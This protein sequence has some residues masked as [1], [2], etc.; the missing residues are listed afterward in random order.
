MD[1]L[2]RSQ[3]HR[4]CK[5]TS[6]R[7]T[8]GAAFLLAVYVAALAM[9]LLGGVSLQR[10]TTEV[11]ASQMSRNVHQSFWIAEAGLDHALM[12][13]RQ[14]K[15]LTAQ[16]SEQL[17][18]TLGN[19][20]Y[21]KFAKFSTLADGTY[22]PFTGSG[23][24]YSFTLQTAK[25]EVLSPQAMQLTRTIT[26]TGTAAGRQSSVAATVVSNALPVSGIFANA[27]ITG[28]NITVMGSMHTRAGIPGSVFLWGSDAR[29][30][31]DL[32]IGTPE[33]SNPYAKLYGG[34]A[35]MKAWKAFVSDPD[36][37]G[38]GTVTDWNG[39][40]NAL[41]DGAGIV[42]AG[43]GY[44]GWEPKH[45]VSGTISA[46]NLPM[47]QPI[48]MPAALQ[49]I[50]SKPLLVPAG[51][52]QLIQDGAVCDPAGP[53][54][55]DLSNAN[56]PGQPDGKILL[57]LDHLA[58]GRQSQLIF[59]APTEVYIDGR[60]SSDDSSLGSN[61]N[62]FPQRGSAIYLGTDSVLV[63]TNPS[64]HTLETGMSLLV[65][66]TAPGAQAGTIIADMPWAFYGSVW[67]PESPA[68]LAAT[69]ALMNYQSWMDLDSYLQD[70]GTTGGLKGM[71]N[72][73][74]VVDKLQ[75]G[76][77]GS[78][79]CSAFMVEQAKD[80]SQ[81]LSYTMTGWRNLKPGVSP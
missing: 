47:I 38:T 4:P 2:I 11:N 52:T 6:L 57:K 45:T 30:F 78:A 7:S 54:P 19:A 36:G 74:I 26:A 20:D 13:L 25:I 18:E 53:L 49:P 80:E 70:P 72:P 35:W 62:G 3:P 77:S 29:I 43:A 65:T 64:G 50:A 27:P 71:K 61:Y 17:G 73:Y 66:K 14:D 22:G 48:L 24:T 15:P 1:R 8:R 55:C 63:A 28:S 9:L 67:A 46:V 51:Q 58:L 23:G 12:L 33:A 32:T 44:S 34:P 56:G 75:L 42:L 21:V 68:Q 5:A 37:D 76:P 79:G 10:T 31:G 40:H 41:V 81:K 60:L 69:F 39:F 59:N 16:N